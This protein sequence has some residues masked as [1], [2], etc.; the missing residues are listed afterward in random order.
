MNLDVVARLDRSARR[1]RLWCVRTNFVEVGGENSRC[2]DCVGVRFAKH[3]LLSQERLAQQSLCLTV[4]PQR[5]H[6]FCQHRGRG[7]RAR[8][9]GSDQLSLRGQHLPGNLHSLGML[10]LAR[11]RLG[12]PGGSRERVLVSWALP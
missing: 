7:E 6:R 2:V 4:L 10:A 8:M 11:K 12:E 3:S 9:L 5:R 1:R